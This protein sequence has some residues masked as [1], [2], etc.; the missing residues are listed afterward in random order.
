MYDKISNGFLT[1]EKSFF[2]STQ[3]ETNNDLKVCVA[4]PALDL[5]KY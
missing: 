5:N 4:T 3:I 2:F 1:T